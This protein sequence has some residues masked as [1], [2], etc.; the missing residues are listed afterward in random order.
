MP[1]CQKNSMSVHSYSRCW[2]HLI[3]TTLD[4]ERLLDKGASVAVS[5]YL[6]DYSREN[7]MYMKINYV[8]A[9]HVHT[10]MEEYE[11]FVKR[12]ALQW[13]D[14]DGKP[15]KGLRQLRPVASSPG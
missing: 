8:N 4:R 6:A 10:F 9:D 11:A 3:W 1:S 7:R 5:G 12:H 2:L 14:D 15:L 13:H